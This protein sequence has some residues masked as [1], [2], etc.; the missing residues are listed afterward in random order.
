MPYLRVANVQRGYLDLAEIKMVDV[1]TDEK[2]KYLLRNGDLLLTEGGDFDKLGRAAIWREQIPV[3]IH[4]NHIFRARPLGAASAEWLMLCTN[5]PYGRDYFLSSSKQTTNLASINSTQLKNC[6]IALPPIAEQQRILAKVDQLFA[7]TRALE[8]RLRQ[9]QA[10]VV[11]VNRAA[12]HRL[13]TAQDDDQFQA[14]WRT[15][16]DHF[17]VLYDDPRNV[18]ELR[19]TILDLAVRGK[20]VAQDPDDEPAEELLKAIETKKKQ[21]GEARKIK[22]SSA[23]MRN[24]PD[25]PHELP[26]GWCWALVDDLCYVGTGST[27]RRDEPDNYEDGQIP[28]I[29]SAVTG[30]PF[31]TEASEYISERALAETNC[32]VY[33]KHTLIV[34]MYG[35]GKTRGQ[36]SELLIEAST[37]QACAALVFDGFSDCIRPYVKLFFQKNYLELRKLAEGGAQPNLNVGKIR[38]ASIPVPPLA[39]QAAHR[40]RRSTSS[41]AVR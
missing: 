2:H 27:P 12:L 3:C 14:A 24:G 20:L 9:A 22:K 23:L 32:Q 18:A 33:P 13:H 6:P 38:S 16:R 40:R 21:F 10:D 19:Q 28:W 36:V 39:E 35:Q 37:N 34:G 25:L 8:A 7:Q 29:T 41:W 15:I 4:Q 30:M 26:D 5:S 1:K 11:T 31:I 17:D